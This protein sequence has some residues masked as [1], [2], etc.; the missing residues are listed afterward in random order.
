MRLFV[1][2]HPFL[3]L[4]A[5]ILFL[6]PQASVIAS[7]D[8]ILRP[9]LVLSGLLLVLVWPINRITSDLRFTGIVLLIVVL[10]LFANIVF[11]LVSLIALVSVFFVWHGYL[12]AR[13]YVERYNTFVNLANLTGLLFVIY[14]GV[15]LYI[16]L[17]DSSRTNPHKDWISLQS[18]D[19]NGSLPDIYYI[20]L[21]G[22][23]RED[24]LK[25]LY[26]FDNSEFLNF[27]KGNG[28][29]VPPKSRSNYPKTALSIA[30]TLNMD[31]IN[32][33]M[34]GIEDSKNWWLMSP[35]I[36]DSRVHFMLGQLGYQSISIASDWGITD[37]S[38][39]DIYFRPC[40]IML[41]DFEGFLLNSTPLSVAR[42]FLSNFAFV[43]SYTSH[44]NLVNYSFATLA[45]VSS[46]PGPK[47]VFAHII[48]PHPPFIFDAEGNYLQPGYSFSFND[49]NDFPYDDEQYRKGY[50]E[51]IQFINLKVEQLIKSI[52]DR[53][54]V[55]PVIILS[56]DHGPGMFSDFRSSENTCLKERFSTF[57]AYY[58]PGI[59][60]S[61]VPDDV[62]SVNI[63]RILFN[64]Y[65]DV[66]IPLLENFFYY[67]KDEIYIFRAED[68]TGFVDSCTLP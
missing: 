47:F 28:F 2:L 34:P 29:V 53:S 45:D 68:I 43:P 3:F 1:L 60:S 25:E 44:G 32:V 56:A 46:L 13:K 5:S 37:N 66:Q 40:Q 15:T 8:Q 65:F 10:G 23:A 61:L 9:I 64:G 14:Y 19:S 55:L 33:L 59:D 58:L 27:L 30:S 4:F 18:D 12:W 42:S 51:Q 21:D 31:Y 11:S 17:P 36:S 63:F 48:A 16:Q 22:Y 54:K 57:S 39:S 67:Y 38:T 41:T 6:Y 26:G 62:S 7:P 20:V 35:L 50:V 49:A 52:I 24:I